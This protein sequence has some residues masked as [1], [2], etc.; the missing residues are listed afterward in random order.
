MFS[1]SA[2]ANLAQ[3]THYHL[4]HPHANQQHT[5]QP[6]HN[7]QHMSISQHL[8]SPPFFSMTQHG[9]NQPTNHSQQPNQPVTTQSTMPSFM[10]AN[11]QLIAHFSQPTATSGHFVTDSSQYMT[12]VPQQHQPT[13]QLHDSGDA[14]FNPVAFFQQ[15]QSSTILHHPNQHQLQHP[16]QQ[17]S[18]TNLMTGNLTNASQVIIDSSSN[19]LFRLSKEASIV[20]TNPA[21]I[22]MNSI[23]GLRQQPRTIAINSSSVGNNGISNRNNSSIDIRQVPNNNNS[24]VSVKL[25]AYNNVALSNSVN[26]NHTTNTKNINSKSKNNGGKKK[27]KPET[28]RNTESPRRIFACPTCCKGFTE[29]FNMKRHMQIHSQSRPKYTCNEC[30]KSFAWKDNFIRHKKAAHGANLQQY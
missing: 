12:V 26:Q 28:H 27:S 4:S 2:A 6:L 30:S 21:S 24:N 25:N 3:Q 7:N 20:D 10:D 9:L 19:G 5:H 13:S 22:V 23:S 18:C 17:I 1:S 8:P 16:Q 11:Q 14:N 15:N 29:K